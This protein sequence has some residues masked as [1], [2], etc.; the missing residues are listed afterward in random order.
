MEASLTT[1]TR[2][3]IEGCELGEEQEGGGASRSLQMSE[4][5]SRWGQFGCGGASWHANLVDASVKQYVDIL[6]TSRLL[7]ML[8]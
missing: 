3:S 7:H 4:W 6:A 5:E 2:N 1:G 8:E